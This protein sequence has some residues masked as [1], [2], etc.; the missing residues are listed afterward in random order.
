MNCNEIPGVEEATPYELYRG[1]GGTLEDAPDSFAEDVLLENETRTTRFHQGE[2]LEK[3]RSS[4]YVKDKGRV[5]RAAKICR[6]GYKTFKSYTR[7]E[8]AS[9]MREYHRVLSSTSDSRLALIFRSPTIHSTI[10]NVETSESDPESRDMVHADFTFGW[11]NSDTDGFGGITGPPWA[12]FSRD[13]RD[14][15]KAI[16]KITIKKGEGGG[17]DVGLLAEADPNPGRRHWTAV[18]PSDE[19]LEED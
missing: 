16:Y 14:G 1:L 11:M 19:H 18:Y 2:L 17:A 4:T 8:T 13:L 12:G 15:Y 7:G 10:C 6:R 3:L 9:G 5:Y